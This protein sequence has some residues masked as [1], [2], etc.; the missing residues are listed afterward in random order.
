MNMDN[1][2][3]RIASK[4]DYDGYYQVKSDSQ[5]IIWGGF[6]KAPDYEGLK[7]VFLRR[8]ESPERKEYV[9]EI[10]HL[11]VGYLSAVEN[12]N[13]VEI[14]YGV[15]EQATGKGVATALIQNVISEFFNKTIIVWV[16]E[17]NIGSE[18]CLLKNGF[19][20]LDVI[21]TRFL[22]LKGT[23]HNFY[24]WERISAS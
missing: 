2:I 8:V 1:R 19:V 10:D 17:Q 14:S 22:P 5:N 20:K 24:K 21:E 7:D 3:I 4:A 15:L 16:S 13:T 6:D 23:E 11:I 9:C 12:G 18:K